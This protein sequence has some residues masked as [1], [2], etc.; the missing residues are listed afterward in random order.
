MQLLININNRGGNF[1][2]LTKCARENIMS[3]SR[4]GKFMA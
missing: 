1:D 3:V 4:A 2:L